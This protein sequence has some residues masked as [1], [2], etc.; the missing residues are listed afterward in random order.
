MRNER[1]ECAYCEGDAMTSV[2][3]GIRVVL[4]V[5]AC[6]WMAVAGEDGSQ[7]LA[8]ALTDP[9]RPVIIKL[10]ISSGSI[11]IRGYDGKEVL[12]TA[13]LRNA[14]AQPRNTAPPP[15]RE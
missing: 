11:V 14:D 3:R 5:A 13:R 10:S 6:A 1:R 7:K 4:G 15:L 12:V 8:V 2:T 9:A